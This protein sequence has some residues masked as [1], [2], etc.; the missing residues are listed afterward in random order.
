[1]TTFLSSDVFAATLRI[2]TPLILAAMGGLL[3]QKAGV[4]N[5]ALAGFMLIGAFCGAAAVMLSGGS[6]WIGFAGAMLGGL[7]I[8][9]LFGLAVVR[10]RANQIISGIAINMMGLGLTSYLMRAA[11]HVQGSLRVG[12]IITK[13]P[14]TNIPLIKDIPYLGGIIGSQHIVTYFSLLVVILVAVTL[15]RTSYGLSVCSLGESED[16]ARTAGVKPERVKWSVIL[17]S[18]LLCGLAGAYLSTN[19]VSEFAENMIQGRGFN[20]FTAVVFGNASPL[21]TF[22]VTL[23]FGYADAV[24]IRL[25]LLGTGIPP[26]IIK[27]FPFAL[28]IIALSISSALRGRRHRQAAS[29]SASRKELPPAQSGEEKKG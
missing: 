9:A 13:I 8:S 23:L 29:R 1:M 10:F 25:E 18:G 28:A 2:A 21:A 24:G 12:D 7:L 17:L 27:M 3:C 11:F 16:A 22:L 26:S 14:T 6:A 15:K 19:I 5:I 20:A 4:F